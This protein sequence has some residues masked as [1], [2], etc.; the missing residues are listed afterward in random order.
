MPRAEA[1]ERAAAAA[2]VARRWVA[3]LWRGVVAVALGRTERGRPPQRARTS[4]RQ[5]MSR[6]HNVNKVCTTTYSRLMLFLLDLK[7]LK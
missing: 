3:A 1:D 7:F 5:Q 2:V 4:P 6:G